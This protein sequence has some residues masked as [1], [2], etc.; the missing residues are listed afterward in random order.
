MLNDTHKYLINSTI[1]AQLYD[2]IDDLPLDIQLKACESALSLKTFI[3][4]QDI[5]KEHSIDKD[6]RSIGEMIS[7]PAPQNISTINPAIL[8]KYTVPPHLTFSNVANSITAEYTGLLNLTSRDTEGFNVTKADV[9]AAITES[10]KVKMNAINVKM[11]DIKPIH[12]QIKPEDAQHEDKI[13]EDAQHEDKKPEVQKIN[14]TVLQDATLISQS[15]PIFIQSSIAEQIKNLKFTL[16]IAPVCENVNDIEKH[17]LF[18]KLLGNFNDKASLAEINKYLEVW[19]NKVKLEYASLNEFC[20]TKNTD[21][22]DIV[23]VAEA[24][25]GKF[26]HYLSGNPTFYGYRGL[27]RIAVAY[28]HFDRLDELESNP[29]DLIFLLAKT[30]TIDEL[31]RRLPPVAKEISVQHANHILYTVLNNTTINMDVLKLMLVHLSLHHEFLVETFENI[32]RRSSGN[33]QKLLFAE[34]LNAPKFKTQFTL[35]QAKKFYQ[36]AIDLNDIELQALVLLQSPN[37]FVATSFL[38]SDI[39][40]K[41]VGLKK[42]GAAKKMATLGFGKFLT[43]HDLLRASELSDGKIGYNSIRTDY[44]LELLDIQTNPILNQYRLSQEG[45]PLAAPANQTQGQ[46]PVFPAAAN[47]TQELQ[48]TGTRPT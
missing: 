7:H 8:P 15:A 22:F 43:M 6:V 36:Y 12:N 32:F 44:S 47:S 41:L 20:G 27:K 48:R 3:R 39:F 40:L 34:F 16:A 29:T 1:Q 11:A 24:M 30:N 14:E 26:D 18:L 13:P 46:Q 9:E 31:R 25:Q 17:H 35:E 42:Y 4:N 38:N 23:S 19:H 21:I 37:E 10:I 5:L 28:G 33:S 45:V 2:Y